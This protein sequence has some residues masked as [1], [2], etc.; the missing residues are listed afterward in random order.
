LHDRHPGLTQALAQAYAEAARV[1][2]S[3][4]HQPAV[5]IEIVHMAEKTGNLYELTWTAP[6]TRESAA[7]A[8]ADDATRDGAYALA[9]ASAEVE[10]GF[11]AVA[12]AETLT[13]ADYYLGEAGEAKGADHLE[14][15]Y[16]LEV[17]GLDRGRRAAVRQ[18]LRRKVNQARRGDSSLPAFAC[19]VGFQ[20]CCVALEQVEGL[21]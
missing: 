13:G 2:L 7:W 9:L 3:R 20:A 11:V 16:R 17:S 21:S 14:R 1:C 15:A 6:Q 12:R 8:N 18:R 10:L 5:R 19:V 4:H